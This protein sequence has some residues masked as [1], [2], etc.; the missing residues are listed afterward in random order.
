MAAA[1]V[2][3]TRTAEMP[4]RRQA[5]QQQAGGIRAYL[6]PHAAESGRQAKR[7]IAGKHG[8]M[9]P[10][11]NCS[12]SGRNTARPYRGSLTAS[13]GIQ[14]KDPGSPGRGRTVPGYGSPAH[15]QGPPGLDGQRTRLSLSRLVY[16]CTTSRV[17]QSPDPG[18]NGGRHGPLKEHK[19]PQVNGYDVLNP[20]TVTA[21]AVFAPK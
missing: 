7:Q 10:S 21:G 6:F 2:D 5:V 15:S 9:D 18:A 14:A 20:L 8:A 12:V 4:T 3:R 16:D 19:D 13:R 11:G 17:E 1:T